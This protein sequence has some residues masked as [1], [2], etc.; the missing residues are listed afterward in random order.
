MSNTAISAPGLVLSF[1][2][3]NIFSEHPAGSASRG[4]T[5][6]ESIFSQFV[7]P[8]SWSPKYEL[9]Y[10]FE[11]YRMFFESSRANISIAHCSCAIQIGNANK[12]WSIGARNLLCNDL[13]VR[14]SYFHLLY[15]VPFVFPP[16]AE[17][18]FAFFFSAMSIYPK[19][20]VTFSPFAFSRISYS[21]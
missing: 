21:R 6:H 18:F 9:I 3:N 19:S 20:W 16:F 15:I 11:F 12:V 4:Q 2:V 17:P 7:V 13:S 10:I 8:D 5:E 14:C 1:F